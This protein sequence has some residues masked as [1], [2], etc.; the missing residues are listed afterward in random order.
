MNQQIDIPE[1]TLD[2]EEDF[3]APDP[4]RETTNMET[5]VAVWLFAAVASRGES[6]GTGKPL[7]SLRSVAIVDGKHTVQT[8][9]SVRSKTRSTTHHTT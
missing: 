9:V 6:A 2:E 3:G 1:E 4:T 7:V 8:A 5:R